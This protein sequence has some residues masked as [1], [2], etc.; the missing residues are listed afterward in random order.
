MK[1]KEK[2]K[3]IKEI[4][5]QQFD[6]INQ[7]KDVKCKNG[8]IDSCVEYAFEIAL[9]AMKLRYLQQQVM[10]I[11]AIKKPNGSYTG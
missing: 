9:L 3:L 7:M 10:K 5:L 11:R 6:L 2:A 8:H 4:H 1:P